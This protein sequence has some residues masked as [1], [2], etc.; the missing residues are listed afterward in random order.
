MIGAQVVL[1]DVLM[2]IGMFGAGGITT[3]GGRYWYHHREHDY[4][5]NGKSVRT[6]LAEMERRLMERHDRT[7][8]SV[9]ELAQ[10]VARHDE[11]IN[12]IGEKVKDLNKS[13]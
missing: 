11:R 4:G 5:F 6:L 13:C 10:V 9:S 8:R 12:A 7:E 2:L 1:G 3:L